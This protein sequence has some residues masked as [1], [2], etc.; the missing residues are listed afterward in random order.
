MHSLKILSYNIVN[1]YFIVY[2]IRVVKICSVNHITIYEYRYK[3]V[4]NLN[5]TNKYI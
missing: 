1:Y 4:P 3:L 5:I 2:A